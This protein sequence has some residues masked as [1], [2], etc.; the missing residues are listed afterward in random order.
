MSV[1]DQLLNVNGVVKVL[2]DVHLF[3]RVWY[4]RK[5]YFSPNFLL[6]GW[7]NFLENICSSKYFIREPSSKINSSISSQ[8]HK[9]LSSAIY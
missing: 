3:G 7:L 5:I 8:Q 9:H 1:H 4:R 6:F 2:S